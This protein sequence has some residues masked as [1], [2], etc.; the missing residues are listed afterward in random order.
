MLSSLEMESIPREPVVFQYKD[1]P[2][3]DGN[4]ETLDSSSIIYSNNFDIAVAVKI[5]GAT[6]RIYTY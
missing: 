2:F 4:K 6:L 5:N 1:M 3:I